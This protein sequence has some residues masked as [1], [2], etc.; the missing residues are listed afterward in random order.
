MAM[1]RRQVRKAAAAAERQ[2][3]E[4]VALFDDADDLRAL[5]ILWGLTDAYSAKGVT[6]GDVGTIAVEAVRFY[7]RSYGSVAQ[8]REHI[9]SRYDDRS[10]KNVLGQP[11]SRLIERRIVSL[12]ALSALVNA[13]PESQDE[14]ARL[15]KL[16]KRP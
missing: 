2:Q 8:T 5:N 4:W 6:S 16:D 1:S 3:D 11:L 10:L 12:V 9:L 14:A 13:R 15:G 7:D